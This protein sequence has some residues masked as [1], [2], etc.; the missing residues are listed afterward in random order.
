MVPGS[1]FKVHGSQFHGS[2]IKGSAPK[3]LMLKR[4]GVG[5]VDFKC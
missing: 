3:Y 5:A 2:R 1:R 4:V